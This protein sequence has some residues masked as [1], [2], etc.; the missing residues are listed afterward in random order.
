MR[1]CAITKE[2]RDYIID[3][4]KDIGEMSTE[5]VMTL[6]EPHFTFDPVQAKS[7]QI[8]KQAHQM[9]SKMRDK[10]GVRTCFAVND[11]NHN[12]VYVNVEKTEDPEALDAIEKQL[13]GKYTGLN[14]SIK[15]VK[16]R[17]EEISGQISFASIIKKAG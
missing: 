13:T 3:K 7:Q 11:I 15:Q 5:E 1:H 17:K 6:I 9:M 10:Y 2:A 4:M 14:A 16:R 12:S 8:R